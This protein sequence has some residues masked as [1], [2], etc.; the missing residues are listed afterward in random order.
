MHIQ[1]ICAETELHLTT[2]YNSCVNG[3]H[4][5]NR[6]LVKEEIASTKLKLSLLAKQKT[7]R[8]MQK[9]AAPV[10]E[11][12]LVYNSNLRMK[13]IS[14][15]CDLLK[16][17]FGIRMVQIHLHKH[18]CDN[19]LI[20]INHAHIIF[21]WMDKETGKS[22]KLHKWDMAELQEMVRNE[23]E[24]MDCMMAYSGNKKET[25]LGRLVK[26]LFPFSYS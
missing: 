19:T 22:I 9:H 7:G 5:Q 26:T 21:N 24:K 14:S 2:H 20:I 10:R 23:I 18:H 15:L 13:H 16:N 17:R 12:T 4:R 6:V 8:S 11:A 1:P 3:L 25:P